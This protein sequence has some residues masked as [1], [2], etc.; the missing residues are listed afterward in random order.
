MSAEKSGRPVDP[1]PVT[2]GE[3]LRALIETRFPAF[4]GRNVREVH[5]IMRRSLED[6]CAVF[7]TLSGAMTPAGLHSSVPHPAGRAR[8]DRLPDDDRREPLPRRAPHASGHRSASCRRWRGRPRAARS[9]G[10]SASTTSAS[11][12]DA[13]RHRQLFLELLQRPE[14]QRKMTTPELHYALGSADRRRRGRAG[15]P[16]ARRCSRPASATTCRSSSARCR[17]ARSS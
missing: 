7:V 1:P 17:T 11:G 13:A 8:P 16:G 10:S 3:S 15:R 4:A 5:R 12:G 9:R 2:G 6:D 14:F